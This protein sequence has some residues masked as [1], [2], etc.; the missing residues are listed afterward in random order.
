MSRETIFL[1]EKP[2]QAR[3]I[4]GVLGVLGGAKQDGFIPTKQGIV[5]WAIGHLLQLCDPDEIDP[6][7]AGGWSL[8]NLPIAPSSFPVKPNP[9]TKSQLNVIKKLLKTSN[10][11]VIATDADREGEMIARELLD[12]C[13][14]KGQIE[15]L[16]LSALDEASIRKALANL[17][18]GESTAPLYYAALSR[19]RADW[20]VGM[21]FTR[22]Y[23]A[24][25]GRGGKTYSVGRVQTPTLALVV[26]RDRA[27]EE[28]RPTDYFTLKA[29]A[30]PQGA[31]SFAM[32]HRPEEKILDQAKAKTLA[33][34]AEGASGLLKVAR[35]KKST[36]PPRL[37]SLST[38]TKAANAAFGWSAKQCLD[39]AQSLYETHKATTYPRSD[40]EYLPNEQES[41]VPQI[42]KHALDVAGACKLELDES[43]RKQLASAPIIRKTV[44]CTA[45]VTAHHAIIPTTVK[46]DLGRMNDNERKA[47]GLIL[48]RY[49]ANLL[50]DYEYEATRISMQA[51]GLEFVASGSV[52]LVMG[53][54]S[55]FAA[56]DTDE[57]RLPNV[58]DGTKA[59]LRSVQ[60][61]Q[62][63]TEPPPR[64]T[65][66]S[67]IEDM[68]SVGKFVEDPELK[69]R[70]KENSGIG[71]EATRANII[72]T[73]F[74]RGFIETKKQGKK[75]VIISTPTGRE[76]LD[77]L[78]R[79]LPALADPARTAIWETEL[80][81]IASG[82]TSHLPF[83]RNIIKEISDQINALKNH[84]K[85][86]SKQLNLK[87]PKSGEPILEYETTYVFPGYPEAS[88]PKVVAQ[89]KIT[90]EEMLQIV[91]D[92]IGP[93]MEGFISKSKKP[94]KAR[95]RFDPNRQYNG[96][97]SPGITF[98]F[99]SSPSESG[100][101]GKELDLK[102]PKTGQPIKDVG[103]AF[104]FGVAGLYGRKTLLERPMSVQDYIAVLEN[105]EG[106]EFDGFRS[107]KTGKTFS[108]TVVF[109]AKS[110]FNGKPGFEFEFGKESRE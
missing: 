66:G 6:Q 65:E 107:K 18:A 86:M 12:Y 100:G 110:K 47:Y 79:T 88:F 73:L 55:L 44:F 54:Q 57:P 61:E 16:W 27:I 62:K 91:T 31:E 104:A 9:K 80:E 11:V 30:H 63:K 20:L 95:L 106:V 15:R 87:C 108:A 22:A 97:P 77:I 67:L 72:A 39:I 13:Q 101:G 21:N 1:C 36:S 89:R 14:W 53:W 59:T 34:A 45:K 40:C 99:G 23:T 29:M 68:K 48:A 26:R 82:S 33:Q 74:S 70:L 50:P 10:R 92:G 2:S 42:V 109:V 60:V 19:S 84:R 103:D 90:P 8:D 32:F 46:P 98:D 71:T 56:S 81:E 76:F 41:D 37:F 69:K 105:P 49:L 17:R 25:M 24:A 4:A 94:F 3:D 5:T 83:V 43:S 102:C 58:Q 96:K 38:F 35:S 7:W 78:E 51:A 75:A 64:Y 85:T 52:P 28:F 93:E